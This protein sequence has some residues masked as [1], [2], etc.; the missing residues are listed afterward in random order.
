M[1]FLMLEKL[2]VGCFLLVQAEVPVMHHMQYAILENY[3]IL[4][5][6]PLMTIFLN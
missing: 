4:K 6:M 3:V 5:L 2:L 1:Y